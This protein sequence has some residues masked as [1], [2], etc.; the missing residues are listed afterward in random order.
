MKS[1]DSLVTEAVE[2]L[3]EPLD[4][5]RNIFSWVNNIISFALAI[6][7]VIPLFAILLFIS[8]NWEA[9]PRIAR[10]LGLVAMALNRRFQRLGDLVAGTMVV[11]EDRHWLTGVVTPEDPRAIELAALIPPSFV[12]SRSLAQALA[13]YVDRR[14]SFSPP[15]RSCCI[16]MAATATPITSRERS[17]LSRRS[18]ACSCG[19]F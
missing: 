16:P 13:T 6:I 9:L 3:E 2:S 11:V 15:M 17:T 5:S 18:T 4:Q 8:A 1:L 14:G 10:L 12:V 19:W 7:A